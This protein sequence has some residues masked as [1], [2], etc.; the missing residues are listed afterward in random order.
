MGK[1]DAC[2]KTAGNAVLKQQ[3]HFLRIRFY[4]MTD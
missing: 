3:R 1:E 4:K 2:F